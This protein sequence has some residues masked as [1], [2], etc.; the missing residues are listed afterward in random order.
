M[1]K[2]YKS[3][4]QNPRVSI[5]VTRTMIASNNDKLQDILIKPQKQVNYTEISEL[6]PNTTLLKKDAF[7]NLI[8]R[9]S[10]EFNSDQLKSYLM[11]E[12]GLTRKIGKNKTLMIDNIISNWGIKIIPDQVEKPKVKY[13]SDGISLLYFINNRNFVK[14]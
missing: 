14:R 13:I 7:Y 11:L 12:I 9:L 8:E 2:V 3:L 5:N 4:K 6:R 10:N 1:L